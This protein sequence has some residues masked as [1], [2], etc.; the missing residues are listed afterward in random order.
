MG[1]SAVKK[2]TLL[3]LDIIGIAQI[4]LEVREGVVVPGH[5]STFNS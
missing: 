1:V 2:N 4:K 5:S 3:I